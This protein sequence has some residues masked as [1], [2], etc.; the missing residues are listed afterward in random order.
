MLFRILKKAKNSRA[1]LGIIKTKNGVIHT[2]AFVP[3]ATQ[4][5]VKGLT[6]EQLK[7]IGAESV[8]CNTYHLYL[9]PGDKTVRKMGGLHQFMN[10]HKPIWTDSGGFQAFS[11]GAA[12]SHGV[13]KIASIFPDEGER[14]HAPQKPKENFVKITEEGV[15]FRS[16]L[17]GSFHLLTPEKSMEIQKNLGADLIF[18]FDECTSPLHDYAYTKKSMERTHRWA[19]RCLASAKLKS[20]NEKVK[21]DG[22]ALFGIVQGGAYK[23]LRVQSAKF[24]GSMDF[25]GFGIGGSLGKSKKDMYKVLDWTVPL[26]PEEKPKHLLG[27]GSAD[28]IWEAVKRGVDTF[29]CVAP[30][31]IAR[32]GSALLAKTALNL[33]SG[34][35]LR[36]K[37]P[38]DKKCGCYTCV[39]Y[40]RAYVSHLFKAHEMLGPILTT[41]HNLSFMEALLR[42]IR[43]RI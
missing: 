43:N 35:Y 6:V 29:D 32:N 2:P 22:Q 13:S 26:L 15:R 42:E 10:W 11:L 39:N 5:A 12:I 8:L 27:I 33:K 31:R 25:D 18:A 37:N 4:A 36:D 17:D 34:R 7:E 20:K 41:I 1:R 3:V 40:T 9:R 24:I 21:T 23:D 30:T 19:V 14:E 38:I 28:D 16:H